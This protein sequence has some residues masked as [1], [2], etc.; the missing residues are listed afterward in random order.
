MVENSNN[1]YT[2][3]DGF[4]D[5]WGYNQNGVLVA[6]DSESY[7]N[8]VNQAAQYVLANEPTGSNYY[9]GALAYDAVTQPP[10][11]TLEPNVYVQVS[12]GYNRSPLTMDQQ[13]KS[14]VQKGALTSVYKFWT[15]YNDAAQ[16]GE[17]APPDLATS[18]IE[19]DWKIYNNDHLTAI[20]GESS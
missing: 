7:W 1:P 20:G 8:L 3:L 6:A 15:V 10:S 14:L 13:L 2:F 16:D 12:E 19:S 11:F 18:S 5:W 9:V 4:N 17:P